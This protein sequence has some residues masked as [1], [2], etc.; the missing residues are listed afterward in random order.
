MMIARSVDVVRRTL[1]WR[2]MSEDRYRCAEVIPVPHRTN[3]I[4]LSF[5]HLAKVA[6]VTP[7]FLAATRGSMYK[8]VELFI[9]EKG[10]KK[11]KEMEMLNNVS[12]VSYL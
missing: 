6:L 11:R 8:D 7:Y 10:M 3:L 1:K 5:A 2:S 12:S 4:F 9:K